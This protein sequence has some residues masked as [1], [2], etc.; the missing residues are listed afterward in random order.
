MDCCSKLLKENS[1]IRMS[2][3]KKFENLNNRKYTRKECLYKKVPIKSF[4]V[5][6]SCSP[7]NDCKRKLKYGGSLKKA[8]CILH[9]NNNNITGRINFTQKNK[10]LIIEYEIMGLSDGLHGFHVHEYGDVGDNCMSACSHFNP[11]N[12]SH[13]G[14]DSS[15]RHLGDLGNILS[16][17]KLAK[18]KIID[19]FL[20]LNPKHFHSI[21]GRSIIIHEKEDDLGKGNNEESLKTGNAGARLACGVIGLSKT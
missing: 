11:Y 9:Q 6:A 7:Y 1:C 18:G 13:G 4:S 3:M 15:E 10:K 21:I 8:V 19:K 17:N 12:T 2:D 14:L 16:K 5:R 20:S